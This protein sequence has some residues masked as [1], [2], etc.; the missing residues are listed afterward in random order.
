MSMA[1]IRKKYGVPAK[2]GMKI[3]FG[4]VFGEKFAAK[5]GTIIGSQGEYLKIRRDGQ[6]YRYELY[7]PTWEIIY[8]LDIETVKHEDC[9]CMSCRPHTT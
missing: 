8:P 9:D 7:H 1:S 5:I 4:L 3:T 2:K 6:D